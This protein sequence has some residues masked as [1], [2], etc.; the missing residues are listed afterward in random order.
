MINSFGS[1]SAD[2]W[3]TSWPVK[4]GQ[5]G[6][7]AERLQHRHHSGSL[8]HLYEGHDTELVDKGQRRPHGPASNP[9]HARNWPAARTSRWPPVQP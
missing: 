2:T 6:S 1:I 9:S 3:R 7:D 8:S 5:D 4:A